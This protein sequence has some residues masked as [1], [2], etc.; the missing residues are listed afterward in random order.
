[1]YPTDYPLAKGNSGA[2]TMFRVGMLANNITS[3]KSYVIVLSL[4]TELKLPE[5][6]HLEGP[7]LF[8]L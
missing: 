4:K 5:E 3:L 8:I 2:R 1:M 7:L 6:K